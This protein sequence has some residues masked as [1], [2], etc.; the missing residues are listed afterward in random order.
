MDRGRATFGS[1]SASVSATA[2]AC[3][4]ARLSCRRAAPDA[5]VVNVI[6]SL[7]PLLL[8]MLQKPV[9]FVVGID[10]GRRRIGREPGAAVRLRRRMYLVRI[11]VMSGKW[12][13]LLMHIARAT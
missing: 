10:P 11:F 13:D 9:V 6:S 4:N 3:A 1:N 8:E 5:V 7:A 12:L 2:K